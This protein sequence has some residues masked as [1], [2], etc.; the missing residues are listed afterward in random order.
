MKRTVAIAVV[1]VSMRA[2]SSDAS[3]AYMPPQA[4]KLVV[5]TCSPVDTS[6]LKSPASPKS[7]EGLLVEGTLTSG[8][9]KP[10][11]A[12]VWVPASEKLSCAKLPA[13][14]VVSGTLSFA[15]CDGDTNPPC[16]IQTSSIFTKLKVA[17]PAAVKP[18]KRATRAE[19]EAEVEAL[20]AENAKLRADVEALYAQEKERS[21]RLEQQ[22]GTPAKTLP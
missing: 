9:D 10:T 5:A 12:K 7:Y 3:C 15:C 8:K 18:V 22:I 2:P 20:R 4:A 21:K 13:K 16:W 1:L 11:V 17:K 19:L 6:K 14:A